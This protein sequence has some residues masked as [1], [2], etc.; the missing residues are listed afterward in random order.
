MYNK[1]LNKKAKLALVGLWYV[2]LPIAL[3]FAKKISVIGFDNDKV[4]DTFRPKITVIQQDFSAIGL[5][6]A[7]LLLTRLSGDDSNFPECCLV[8][9]SFQNGD[10]VLQ[11]H[12][13][14]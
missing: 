8:N 2:G 5:Q 9:T 13:R 14:G 3:E 4:F 10:S 11:I 6:S 12:D 7:Q 1:L